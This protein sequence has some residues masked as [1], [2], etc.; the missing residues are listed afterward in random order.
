MTQTIKFSA[1]PATGHKG[2]WVAHMFFAR[3]VEGLPFGALGMKNEYL[4]MFPTKEGA[5]AA[6]EAKK[7]ALKRAA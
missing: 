5:L 7:A 1:A 6:I 4:G 3:K 2:K